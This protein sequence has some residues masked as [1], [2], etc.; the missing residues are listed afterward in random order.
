MSAWA[1]QEWERIKPLLPPN[2]GPWPLLGSY[3]SPDATPLVKLRKAKTWDEAKKPAEPWENIQP[4]PI[5]EALSWIKEGYGV[6]IELQKA[7]ELR[8]EYDLSG[9]PPRPLCYIDIDELPEGEA[10]KKLLV[11]LHANNVPILITRRGVHIV[12]RDNLRTHKKAVLSTPYGFFPCEVYAPDSRRLLP[13]PVKGTP[14]QVL[15]GGVYGEANPLELPELLSRISDA[16]SLP[17]GY[18][19]VSVQHKTKYADMDAAEILSDL[20]CAERGE[21]HNRLLETC[22]ELRKR[23]LLDDYKDAVKK[24]AIE[25]F[26]AKEGEREFLSVIKWVDAHIKPEKPRPRKPSKTPEAL[27][28][29]LGLVGVAVLPARPQYLLTA[30]RWAISKTEFAAFA[31]MRGIML[32]EAKSRELFPALLNML[33][34]QVAFVVPHRAVMYGGRAYQPAPPYDGKPRIYELGTDNAQG[35]RCVPAD[36]LGMFVEYSAAPRYRTLVGAGDEDVRKFV[37]LIAKLT[38]MPPEKARYYAALFAPVMAGL[39]TTIV[40]ITGKS[41][42]G[43][44]TL[45][46]V[47]QYA[48]NGAPNMLTAQGAKAIDSFRTLCAIGSVVAIDENR[49]PEPELQ[50]EIRMFVSQAQAQVRQHHTYSQTFAPPAGGSV[51]L[52]AVSLSGIAPDTAHRGI[53][54]H[55][56]K[57]PENRATEVEANEALA[58]A[59]DRL[60]SIAAYMCRGLPT[61][62]PEG[63]PLDTIIAPPTPQDLPPAL[64]KDRKADFARAYW[65]VCKNMGCA[66]STAIEVWREARGGALSLGLGLWDKVAKYIISA[67]KKELE[68]LFEGVYWRELV[69]RAIEYSDPEAVPA[70]AELQKLARILGQKAAEAAGALQELGI[71]IEDAGRDKHGKKVRVIYTPPETEAPEAPKAETE[72]PEVPP[73][74]QDDGADTIRRALH[75]A[76]DELSA[77]GKL[78]TYKRSL[79]NS[80]VQAFLC[81][82]HIGLY[83]LTIDINTYQELL[84]TAAPYTGELYERWKAWTEKE[85]L[86]PF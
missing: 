81:D 48:A 21:R 12:V 84:S 4:R 31:A 2:T 24:V 75:K 45:G 44:S 6:A 13:L 25:L 46:G 1:V 26:G 76:W 29:E 37:Q 18:K 78:P 41:G 73:P 7:K 70:D 85:S 58:R 51:V 34:H 63:D 47:L 59:A 36:V 74:I 67:D 57:P 38:G 32:S 69:K 64:A 54:I 15:G 8:G 5:D 55:L 17:Q 28:R 43:K 42:T 40:M 23:G 62:Q 68:R 20:S 49:A 3:F 9:E 82:R 77:K 39:A 80:V 16:P 65:H 10:R 22:I 35:W 50:A 52:T 33:P 66:D 14:R 27:V 60:Q 56:S 53:H 86:I 11:D 19:I 71:Q 72:A 79:I 83:D 30:D 61:A